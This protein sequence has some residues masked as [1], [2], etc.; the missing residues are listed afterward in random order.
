MVTICYCFERVTQLFSSASMKFFSESAQKQATMT[1]AAGII[2]D[3]DGD[4]SSSA[5]AARRPNNGDDNGDGL[6][7]SNNASSSNDSRINSL[8]H[9]SAAAAVPVIEPR[10][11]A[12]A[13]TA[14]AAQSND[15]DKNPSNVQFVDFI[16]SSTAVKH[17]FS[18][19][20]NTDRNVSVALHNMGNGTFLLDSGEDFGVAGSARVASFV[21]ASDAALSSR[22][23]SGGRGTSHGRR[24]QRPTSWSIQNDCCRASSM[25]VRCPLAPTSNRLAKIPDTSLFALAMT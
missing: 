6:V 17:L 5:C 25:H 22:G 24:R 13:S 19:P 12:D 16:G 3:E 10:I 2:V 8:N 14:G 20:Y 1:T 15:F 21:S 9:V 4:D 18:L 7:L 23:E 11:V